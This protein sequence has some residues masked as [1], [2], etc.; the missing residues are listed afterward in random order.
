MVDVGTL[1]AE[2][3]E[4]DNG[5]NGSCDQEWEPN[6]TPVT[7]L[8][9]AASSSIFIYVPAIRAS[10]D[11][12]TIIHQRRRSALKTLGLVLDVAKVTAIETWETRQSIGVGTRPSRAISIT[13][14]FIDEFS[15]TASITSNTRVRC[16]F[17]ES[18]RRLALNADSIHAHIALWTLVNALVDKE[19]GDATLS[20]AASACGFSSS[21]TLTR[22]FTETTG[23][24]STLIHA[25]SA[26]FETSIS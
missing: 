23:S 17:A 20:E 6:D 3:K 18:T 7:Q 15:A 25:K 8:P 4:N 12:A 16:V 21:T 11:T 5:E 1:L 9:R 10:F 19:V 26:L 2:A 22:L 14:I 13:L 24:V